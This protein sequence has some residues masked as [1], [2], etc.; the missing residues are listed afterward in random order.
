[1]LHYN[2]RDFFLLHF[3]TTRKLQFSRSVSREQWKLLKML[4]KFCF[5]DSYVNILEY[6]GKKY[7][8][9]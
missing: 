9:H 2:T 3:D 5:V 7:R 1:M 4:K 8:L 6:K